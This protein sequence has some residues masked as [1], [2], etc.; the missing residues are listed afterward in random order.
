[1]PPR[2]DV[3]GAVTITAALM[4]AVYA[5]VNGN[6]VGWFVVATLWKL[7]LAVVLFVAFLVIESRVRAPLM[8]MSLFRLKSV[9]TA[10]VMAVLWAA[11][12][13]AWFF[14]SALYLQLVLRATADGGGPGVPAGEPDHGG[15]LAGH[16][17]E[18]GDALRHPR[19]AGARAC[20]SRRAACCCSRARRWTAASGWTWCRRW[21]CSASARASRSIRCCWRR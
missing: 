8:P 12:I 5:I 14:I 3:A 16:L 13:F 4:L 20:W 9:S 17:G 6:E 21:R 19:A 10:N 18:A 1:M 15:V 7:G 2:L 11:G